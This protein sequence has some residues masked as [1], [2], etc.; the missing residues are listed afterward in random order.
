M[1][2]K[3]RLADDEV[4]QGEP[5]EDEP[6]EIEVEGE[7][8]QNETES[9]ERALLPIERVQLQTMGIIPEH[10]KLS[11]LLLNGFKMIGYGIG[12]AMKEAINEARQNRRKPVARKRRLMKR[13]ARV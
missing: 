8:L 10:I 12:L 11:D 4:I 7:N 5:V 1:A 13:R 2:V 3:F 6:I 9:V